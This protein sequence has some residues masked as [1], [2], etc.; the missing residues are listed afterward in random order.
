MSKLNSIR[1]L[2]AGVSVLALTAL[3]APA[4]AQTIVVGAPEG[5]APA[6]VGGT[7]LTPGA[8]ALGNGGRL[9]FNHTDNS[10]DGYR[11][12]ETTT[13]TGG[14]TARIDVLAGHTA[15]TR[16]GSTGRTGGADGFAGLTR[17]YGGAVLELEQNF[18]TATRNP[19]SLTSDPFGG[20]ILGGGLTVDSGSRLTGQG[21]L[22][23]AVNDVIIHGV[24]SPH[25]FPEHA[26]N[27]A[28]PHGRMN[29]GVATT[30]S[31]ATAPQ[32]NALTFAA[33]SILEIDVDL[34]MSGDDV[35]AA[36]LIVPYI[37][38]VIE[39]GAQLRVRLAAQAGPTAYLVGRRIPFLQ[40]AS[41][42]RQETEYTFS[43]VTQ[44]GI[45]GPKI[46]GVI[47][48]NGGIRVTG[49]EFT[50]APA[51]GTRIVREVEGQ[52]GVIRPYTFTYASRS[53]RS[54]RQLA[55]N[56]AFTADSDTQLT[57]YL[58]LRIAD[59][60]STYTSSVS[61]QWAGELV[62]VRSSLYLEIAQTRFFAE[63]ATTANGRAAAD[64]LQKIG[65]FNP[66]FTRLLNLPEGAAAIDQ[67][68]PFFNALSGEL[69]VGVRGLLTQDAYAVQRSVG[70]R[71]SSYEPGGAYLWA[72]ALGGRRQLDDNGEAPAI[73]E[74]GY[75]VLT[76]ID[77]TL[78]GPWRVGLAG[79]WRTVEA[80]GPDALTG[81]ADIKQWHAMAYTAGGWGAWRGQFGAGFS[82]A[83]VETERNVS[84]VGIINSHLAADYDGTVAHAFGELSYVHDIGG[85]A[86]EPF[87]GY[88]F[89][90]AETD[91]V[92]EVETR[93]GDDAAALLIS[94][95]QNQVSFT[96][97]G[98][99]ARTSALERVSLD[100]LVGWRRGFGDLDLEGLHLMNNRE[101]LQVRGARLSENAAVVEAG[102]RWRVT[103]RMT[104]DAGYDGLIG[105][106]GH[107]HTAR[108]GVS[109][110]F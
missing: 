39:D 5:S 79:G 48:N 100:G 104:V 76:G 87:L 47:A 96:T 103:D 67:L 77:A 83:T 12:A 98:V 15:L 24:I 50:V 86:V 90:R 35:L 51:T 101:Y 72:E 58:G 73:K 92:R 62:T 26:N 63:D 8:K 28:G 80:E 64:A 89:V 81:K 68:S 53:I 88:S 30:P 57:H 102:A 4:L 44:A 45:P 6:A 61:G 94:G 43:L 20:R 52:D 41:V 16:V 17:V 110:R 29:I 25:G 14:V 66:I 7:A 85:A 84:L 9:I 109:M 106:E 11:V 91:P 54:D 10:E 19:T 3:A 74:E 75:G 97:L 49:K 23:D 60:D 46:G 108:V 1:G 2:A 13:I 31:A 22:G 65:D 99:K 59:G 55:G 27:F 34:S 93:G 38:T 42:S 33:D 21:A 32:T 18:S 37:N 105:D 82:G 107:D 36:D 70:R 95:D 78:T 40:L 56:F 69:H 71:L